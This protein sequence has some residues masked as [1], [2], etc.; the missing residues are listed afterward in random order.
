MNL[1]TDKYSYVNIRA[2]PS[3]RAELKAIVTP[4]LVK[5]LEVGSFFSPLRWRFNPP[6]QHPNTLLPGS[7]LIHT[8]KEDMVEKSITH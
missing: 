1:T 6:P 2:V 8:S 3:S 5:K 7:H 4:L